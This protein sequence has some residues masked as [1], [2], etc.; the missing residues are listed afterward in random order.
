M[1]NTGG[2]SYFKASLISAVPRYR[3]D[4]VPNNTDQLSATFFSSSIDFL[5]GVPVDHRKAS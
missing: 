5:P 2:F 4:L 3:R 1:R